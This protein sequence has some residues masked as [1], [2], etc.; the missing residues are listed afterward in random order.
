M[1]HVDLPYRYQII[2]CH[3]GEINPIE[4]RVE[5]AWFLLLNRH[6]GEVCSSVRYSLKMWRYSAVT[7][8][9]RPVRAY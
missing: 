8:D 6:Q 3:S 2:S 1:S 5:S 9:Y 7:I 4:T